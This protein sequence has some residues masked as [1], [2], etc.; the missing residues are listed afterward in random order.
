VYQYGNQSISVASQVQYVV[1]VF[2]PGKDLQVSCGFNTQFSGI[3]IAWCLGVFIGYDD[4]RGIPLGWGLALKH[5]KDRLTASS[6][7]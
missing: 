7:A 4:Y 3:L 6:P 2:F 1:K 5:L